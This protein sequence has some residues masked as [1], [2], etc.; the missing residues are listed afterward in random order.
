MLC[1]VAQVSVNDI[2]QV[3]IMLVF[4]S[5]AVLTRPKPAG[6]GRQLVIIRSLRRLKPS[7][8]VQRVTSTARKYLAPHQVAVGV[9]SG[10]DLD[11]HE[12]RLPSKSTV[13]TNITSVCPR[14]SPRGRRT[15]F[16]VSTLATPSPKASAQRFCLQPFS[17]CWRSHGRRT[18]FKGTAV[19][20]C[21]RLRPRFPQRHQRGCVL[22][23][24]HFSLVSSYLQG[25]V[26]AMLLFSLVP[27]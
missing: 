8:V 20:P 4:S 2:V 12:V 15:S 7:V 27:N 6:G 13:Q 11:D 18:R 24:F 17:M 25:N 16:S 22:A 5:A 10:C 3:E 23:M 21:R 26:L 9:K 1:A 14:R 19:A